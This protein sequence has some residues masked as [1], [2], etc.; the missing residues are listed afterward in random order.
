MRDGRRKLKTEAEIIG[1]LRV[2]AF[3]NLGFGKRVQ[4][5]IA[6]HTIEVVGIFFK[7]GYPQAYPLW[8]RPLR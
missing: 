3:N 4:G 7:A 5:G 8:V 2:P 6:L 1:R